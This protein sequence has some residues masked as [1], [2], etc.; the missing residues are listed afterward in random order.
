MISLTSITFLNIMYTYFIKQFTSTLLLKT[1]ET[2]CYFII[3]RVFTYCYR[4]ITFITVLC[5]TPQKLSLQYTSLRSDI[6]LNILL[7]EYLYIFHSKL[8]ITCNDSISIEFFAALYCL[9]Y[10]I[11]AVIRGF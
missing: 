8:I 3:T 5:Y 7:H 2:S 6:P 4:G 1:I 10:Y 9:Y 11:F